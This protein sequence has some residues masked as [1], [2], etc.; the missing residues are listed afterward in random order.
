MV[1]Y[2]LKADLGVF[3]DGDYQRKILEEKLVVNEKQVFLRNGDL[4]VDLPSVVKEYVN[5]SIKRKTPKMLEL[6]ADSLSD[7][8]LFLNNGFKRLFR[9]EQIWFVDKDEKGVYVYSLSDFTAENGVRDTSD[10]IEKYRKRAFAA[11]PD[12]E[13]INS[14]LS[15]KGSKNVEEADSKDRKLVVLC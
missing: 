15:I 4:T 9:K 12:P 1:E 10:I 13:L 3:M 6:A 7:T 11:L 5:K 8:E 14:L 2:S